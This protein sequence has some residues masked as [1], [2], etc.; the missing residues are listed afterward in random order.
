MISDIE[1]NRTIK[2]VRSESGL[3]LLWIIILNRA[4]RLDLMEKMTFVQR[5]EIGEGVNLLDI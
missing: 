5:L 3:G 2:R 1:K 4:V